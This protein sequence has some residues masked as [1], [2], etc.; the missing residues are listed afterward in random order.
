MTT[1]VVAMASEWGPG[2]AGREPGV[3]SPGDGG[4]AVGAG[5]DADQGDADLHG[6]QEPRRVLGHGQGQLGAL[7]AAIGEGLEPGLAG[8]DHRQFGH[9]EDPVQ[10]ERGEDDGER[11]EDHGPAG[12]RTRARTATAAPLPCGLGGGPGHTIQKKTPRPIGPRR[13]D[14]RKPDRRLTR[15]DAP[16]EPSW[17]TTPFWLRAGRGAAG[18]GRDLAGNR[19]DRWR[20]PR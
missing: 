3:Q 4:L 10:E 7:V 9:G 5:Q 18:S 12:S 8:R 2:S 20:R 19:H 6:R 13:H 15:P 11:D 14:V 16:S 17:F 1:I